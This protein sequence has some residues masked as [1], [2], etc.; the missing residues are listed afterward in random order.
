MKISK[1]L[2][3]RGTPS[4]NRLSN[5][6]EVKPSD[7]SNSD[8]QVN[9]SYHLAISEGDIQVKPSD[10]KNSYPLHRNLILGVALA[11]TLTPSLV[12]AGVSSAGL[13]LA[14]ATQV[15]SNISIS[16]QSASSRLRVNE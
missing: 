10:S 7:K 9:S 13:Q 15:L 8:L 4:I 3:I 14:N 12:S 2:G 11:T 1:L 5:L 16:S 6:R